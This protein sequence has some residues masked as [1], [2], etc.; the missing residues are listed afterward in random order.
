LP[1]GVGFKAGF[2]DATKQAQ[3]DREFQA[4]QQSDA[5]TDFMGRAQNLP[6][7]APAR[8]FKPF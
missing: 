4:R 1:G 2:E 6:A 3:R 5:W 8:P 7:I